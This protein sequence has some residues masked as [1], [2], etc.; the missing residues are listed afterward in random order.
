MTQTI[1]L[2]DDY[3]VLE[4]TFRYDGDVDLGE[5]SQEVPAFFCDRDLAWY[6][7]YAGDRPWTGDSLTVIEPLPLDHISNPNPASHQSEEW[8]AY[9]DE[10]GYGIG[11]YTPGTDTAVYYTF[12]P[13]PSACG[14]DGDCSTS[15]FSGSCSYFA[16]IRTLH[17]VRGFS[18]SYKAYLTI[19]R[20]DDIRSLFRTL[21]GN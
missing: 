12:G 13:R 19:G 17:I 4:F 5:A 2:V 15:A 3:A 6:A 18:F 14:S 16:P 20:I 8:C 7:R 9:I 1:T 21:S 11:L 10:S